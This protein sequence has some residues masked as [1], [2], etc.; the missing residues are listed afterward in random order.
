[1]IRP[2]HIRHLQQLRPDP[3]DEIPI[4]WRRGLVWGRGHRVQEHL[5]GAEAEVIVVGH[6]AGELLDVSGLGD[7]GEEVGHFRGGEVNGED[8]DAFEYEHFEGAHREAVAVA[9]GARL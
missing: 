9:E 6:P 1:M 5:D 8:G 3:H 7:D 2:P 4:Q